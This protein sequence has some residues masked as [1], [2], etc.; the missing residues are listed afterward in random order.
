LKLLDRYWKRKWIGFS[1]SFIE[2]GITFE[3]MLWKWNISYNC[4]LEN[5][6]SEFV[7]NSD[8]ITLLDCFESTEYNASVILK[9]LKLDNYIQ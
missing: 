9:Y 4:F 5:Y 7:K 2:K 8:R 1:C 6:P 3:E